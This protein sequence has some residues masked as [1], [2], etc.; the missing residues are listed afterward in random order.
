[1]RLKG[2]MLLVSWWTTT[3]VW[4]NKAKWKSCLLCKKLFKIIKHT[5]LRNIKNINSVSFFLTLKHKKWINQIGCLKSELNVQQKI[6]T[7]FKQ[8]QDLSLFLWPPYHILDCNIVKIVTSI[9]DIE[10]LS[11]NCMEKTKKHLIKSERSSIKPAN[12]HL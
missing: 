9:M 7:I 10:I 6:L 4:F 12:N 3:A 1:M 11:E 8:A 2:G 5:L